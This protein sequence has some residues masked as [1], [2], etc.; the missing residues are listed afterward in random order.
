MELPRR[1]LC[2]ILTCPLPLILYLLCL[3]ITYHFVI[4]KHDNYSARNN[5]KN[6]DQI[7]TTQ[8]AEIENGTSSSS[9]NYSRENK[10][11]KTIYTGKYYVPPTSHDISPILTSLRPFQNENEDDE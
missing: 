2:L 10:S 11:N 8:P 6:R 4:P 1:K 9:K 3:L 5:S 7:Q